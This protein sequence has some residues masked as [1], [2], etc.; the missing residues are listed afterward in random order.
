MPAFTPKTTPFEHQREVFEATK[1]SEAFAFFWEM[2]CGKSKPVI[3]TAAHLWLED[4]IDAMLVIAPKAVAP[5]WVNDELPLHMPDVVMEQAK[6]F[7]WDTGK[8]GNKGFQRDL[9]K[10]LDPSD[11]KFQILVMSYP[12]IM[13]QRSRGSARGVKKGLEA[14]QAIL[15]ERRALFVLDESARIKGTNTKVT[16]RILAASQYA[17][18]RRTMTGTPLTQSPFDAYTQLKFLDADVWKR[19][20][21]DSPEAFRTMFGV[22]VEHVRN[23]NGQKFKQLVDYQNLPTLAKIVDAMGD[24]K[25]KDDV[26]DLPPKLYAKRHFDMA[27]EQRKMYEKLRDEFLVELDDGDIISAPLAI[28]RILRLQQVTSGYCPTDDGEMVLVDPNPRLACLNDLLDDV[29]HHAII[30]A[31]FQRDVDQI[32]ELLAKRGD[33]HVVYDGRTSQAD[34][35]ERRSAFKEGKAKYFVANPAAAGEGLTLTRARTVIYYNTSFKLG[36]R[37]QSEDRAHRIGQE[38]PVNYVDIVATGTIDTKIIANLRK[39]VD[40]AA[41]VLGDR[42]KEWI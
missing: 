41:Q 28:Q 40:L 35:E 42:L 10:F 18:Y 15:K 20:G 33:S 17:K 25:L 14:A 1:D 2:G 31:K 9:A 26:L 13:T 24:R 16:K 27:P 34:R 12:A 7:L 38:H 4:E 23:D 3:D 39:K 37:L 5:N 11:G 29:P 32:A 8:A 21:C 36:D 6:V 19:V 30:W 22:W